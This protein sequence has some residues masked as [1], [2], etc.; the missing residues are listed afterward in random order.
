LNKSDHEATLSTLGPKWGLIK[1]NDYSWTL[2]GNLA[3]LWGEKKTRMYLGA[4]LG[5]MKS[6]INF[7]KK[8]YYV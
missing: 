4:Y 6:I 3:Q 8:K 1:G 5:V 7:T 2:M